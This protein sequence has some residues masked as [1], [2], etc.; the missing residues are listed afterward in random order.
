MPN[1]QPHTAP[2]DA[3]PLDDHTVST[4]RRDGFVL[5]RRVAPSSYV[6]AV[7]P[8][9]ERVVREVASSRDPQGR[10]EDYGRL[11]IQVTNVW[12]IDPVAREFVF[13]R[14]FA[15]IAATLLGVPAVRLY[16]D[17]ALFKP[18]GGKATPWHQDQFYWPLDT[19]KTVTMWMPL[20]DL[21]RDMG[22]MIFAAGSHAQG[23]LLA[24]SISDES[25][26][27]YERIVRDRGW[28]VSG[29]SLAAGDATFHT[30]WCLHATH[31]NSSPDVRK[32]MTVIYYADGARVTAPAS[33]FQKAD[34]E[35]FLAGCVPGGPAAGPLNPVLYGPSAA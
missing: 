9:I 27:E 8:S 18:A 21:T 34:M 30:G 12:R 26:R 24:S 14:R 4:F 28:T 13:A 2:D 35:A 6:A 22:T 19:S 29:E 15:R 5:L 17:Q 3:F 25:H 32:V 23:P 31:P 11:F 20:I 16:H 10:I 1:D 33:D 7:R